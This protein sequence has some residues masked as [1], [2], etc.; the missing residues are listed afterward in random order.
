[1]KN[2]ASVLLIIIGVV[3]VVLGIL[4][5]GFGVVAMLAGGKFT[6]IT[7]IIGVILYLG[8]GTGAFYGGKMLRK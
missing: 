6:G 8:L 7:W 1:M 3:L 2:A 5:L 4:T